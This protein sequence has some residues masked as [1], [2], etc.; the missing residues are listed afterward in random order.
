MPNLF[1]A[2]RR[3]T[4]ADQHARTIGMVVL[5]SIVAKTVQE[6]FDKVETQSSNQ[7][8][9]YYVAADGILQTVRDADTS[10]HMNGANRN[11]ISIVLCKEV[12]SWETQ[13]KLIENAA[14]LIGSIVS[15]HHLPLTYIDYVGLRMGW[16]GV[17]TPYDVGIAFKMPP[18]RNP[19][20]LDILML[21]KRARIASKTWL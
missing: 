17:T 18:N 15:A 16:R 6:A 19:H 1:S 21:I 3:Y 20:G 9:H 5:Y 7:S 2:T 8:Y 4:P 11:S 13:E 10:W 12:G 14:S